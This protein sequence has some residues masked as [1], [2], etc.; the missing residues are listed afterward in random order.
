MKTQAKRTGILLLL[1]LSFLSG[2]AVNNTVHG[3][4]AELDHQ[5]D[6]APEYDQRKEQRLAELKR[7]LLQKRSLEQTHRIYYQLYKEY[8]AYKFD[9]AMYYVTKH[10]EI[11]ELQKNTYWI[12]ECK[13]GLSRMYS[14]FTGFPEAIDLLRSIDKSKL[15]YEQLSAYYNC[16]AEVYIYWNEYVRNEDEGVYVS[17]K[18]TYQDSALMV[19]PK[20]TYAYSINFGR[21]CIEVK[22]FVR[23]ESVL[24]PQLKLIQPDTREYAILNA[25]IAYLYEQKGDA[26]R[27][28]EFLTQSAIADIKA[29]VKE[30]VSIRTLSLF[31]LDSG[32]L[33][34]ANRYIK[35]SLDDANFY[36]AR[37][38]NIQV[39]KIL[40]IIDKAYQLEREKHQQ[41]LQRAIVLIGL[42]TFFLVCAVI[43][44]VVQMRRLLRTRKALI[45]TQNYLSESNRIKEEYIG[46]FLDQCS[47]YINK[48]DNYRKSLNRATQSGTL[49][50]LRRMLKSSQVIDTELKEFYQN[51]DQ[52]FIHLFPD[53]VDKFNRLFDEKDR[54]IP[55]RP[56]EL[57]VELR[58][59]ALMRLGITNSTKIA[60]LLRYSITTIYN[61]HS[62][63]RHKALIPSDQFDETIM[64]L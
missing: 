12:N 6:L 27:Q 32:D 25:M 21:K 20:D 15:T 24:F 26:V 18:N 55:K 59:F 31:L 52:A 48:L 64:K 36:N 16:F 39:A 19:M 1:F 2:F 34:H 63:Y 35:K 22:D 30:N 46:H 7:Q 60:E 11:A 29:S 43:W 33:V 38:R 37:L 5:L 58:I 47:T 41:V 40:P 9:S 57:T 23:A 45:R 17:L 49:E 8:E 4:F 14:T 10:L 13:M 42:L 61:Y 53:F 62:K 50:D 28:E 51:F 44:L 3:L 56:T 54:I